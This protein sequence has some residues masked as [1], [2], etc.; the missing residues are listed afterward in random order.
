VTG[1]PD[2]TPG[3]RLARIAIDGRVPTGLSSATTTG[4]LT[5]STAEVTTL[6]LTVADPRL[7]VLASNL[8]RLGRSVTYGRLSLVVV[9]RQV[10][11]AGGVPTLTI[12]AMSAGAQR[13]RAQRG[14][15]V[16]RDLSPSSYVAIGA[17]AAGLRA[18]TQATPVRSSITRAADAK[19]SPG[20]SEYDVW[21]RLA[22]EVGFICF[23][24]AGVVYFGHPTWLVRE[25]PTVKLAYPSERRLLQIPTCRAQTNDLTQPVTVDAAVTDSLA[26][27]LLPGVCC[28]LA[29]VPTFNGR[30]I[31]TS[32]TIPLDDSQ[33][34]TVAAA[35]PV[36]P[37]ATADAAGKSIKKQTAAAKRKAAADA[38]PIGPFQ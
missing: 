21:Q 24:V 12:E 32:T 33:P 34:C 16:R 31:V 11:D 4:S 2:L 1:L 25:L 6:E 26:D 17:A 35:T 23:E 27:A 22:G 3:G 5:V 13:A 30:Y 8:F 20:E 36:D 14:Q 10:A 28:E 37:T 38:E 7:V 29:G 15:L 9:S 19:G 18:V